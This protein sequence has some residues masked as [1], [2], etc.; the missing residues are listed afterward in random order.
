METGKVQN[1]LSAF[2]HKIRGTRKESKPADPVKTGQKGESPAIEPRD[3]VKIAAPSPGQ[4]RIKTHKES[5]GQKKVSRSPSKKSA[6]QKAK[7]YYDTIDTDS[8]GYILSKGD[9][10]SRNLT[11]DM[12][13]LSI[14]AALEY[15]LGVSGATTYL[16][17]Q[18]HAVMV[19]AFY[20]NPTVNVQ[21]D[22]IDNVKNLIDHPSP[23][24]LGKVLI[25]HDANQDGAAGVT[26]Y[27]YGEG[28]N[29]RGQALGQDG[30]QSIVFAAGCV[31]E[32]IPTLI[33]FTAGF[34]LRK[35]HPLIGYSL[36]SLTGIHHAAT[37]MYPISALWTTTAE[38]PGH[39]WASF[40]KHTGIHPAVTAAVFAASLPA[41]G[42]ALWFS[43][44]KQEEKQKDK[45][46]VT[47]LIQNGGI[48]ID[49]IDQAYRDY[50][51]KEKLEKAQDEMAEVLQQPY[52][53]LLNDRKLQKKL[54]KKL[55]SLKKEY[56]RFSLHL[57]DKFREK[58][59]EEKKN[60]PKPPEMSLKQTA[61]LLK[62]DYKKAWKEDKVGTALSTGALAGATTVAGKSIADAAAVAAGSSTAAAVGSTLGSFI[63]GVSMLGTAAATWRAGRVM[64]DPTKGKI[65]KVASASIAAFSALG[66]AGL[67]IPGLGLPA[68]IASVGGI[69]GTYLAK[70]IAKKLT[71]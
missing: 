18:G 17:E 49:E 13:G 62:E 28:L 19:K 54:R 40:A 63:P 29:E 70:G 48:K 60:L 9:R 27:D 47:R 36:M 8:Q 66:T 34:K 11:A 55:H 21:V 12:K 53:K 14:G 37:S 42:A 45:I 30:V 2:L 46:A 43:E 68:M 20:K 10:R 15:G 16:H 5:P 3:E 71:S 35:K 6:G 65:D 23:Q 58:V 64:K 25:G 56:D 59:D 33:G 32:E 24:N 50:S 57:A 38:R 26:R 39:D 7:K 1:K 4:D 51:R 61:R 22:G 67:M 31:A 44:K 69:L 41:L 52:S